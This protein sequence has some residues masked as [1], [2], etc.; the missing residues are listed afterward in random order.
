MALPTPHQNRRQRH[1]VGRR[2]VVAALTLWTAAL[3]GPAS[4][5]DNSVLIGVVFPTQ[6]QARW[7]TEEKIFVARAQSHGDK[8]IFQYS[9]ESAATQKNQV[10]GSRKPLI[11]DRANIS[12]ECPEPFYHQRINVL[13]SK[14]RSVERPHAESLTSQT[15]SFFS[16]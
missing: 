14:K 1:P 10:A 16:D 12:S 15:T 2:A 3:A 6:N 13:I 4:A 11:M 7:A 9:N 8:V 5:A